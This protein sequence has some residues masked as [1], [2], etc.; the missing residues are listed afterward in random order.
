MLSLV[1]S[2][3][4]TIAASISQTISLTY[5]SRDITKLN[6]IMFPPGKLSVTLVKFCF[7]SETVNKSCQVSLRQ[8]CVV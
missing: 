6:T 2:G 7:P 5:C 8:L 1:S 4:R 3:K